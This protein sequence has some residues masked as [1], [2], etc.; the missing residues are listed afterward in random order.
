VRVLVIDD[1]TKILENTLGIVEEAGNELIIP[2]VSS[3]RWEE[4]LEKA[5]TCDVILLDLLM[6]A[7]M[8]FDEAMIQEKVGVELLQRLRREHCDVPVVILTH[9]TL[10]ADERAK[11]KALGVQHVLSK[12]K[13]QTLLGLANTLEQ[14]RQSGHAH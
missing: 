2:D 9:L 6:D 8:L 5:R 4:L 3:E 11:L 14:A 10:G 7:N 1:Q 13:R 12:T